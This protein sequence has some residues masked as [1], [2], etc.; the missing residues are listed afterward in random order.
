MPEIDALPPPRALRASQPAA[1]PL[2]GALIESRQR[3][4]DLV[5]MAADLAFETDAW[6]RFSFLAPDAVLGW[7]ASTLLGQPA[8]LLLADPANGY[9]PF[10][11]VAPIQR[12]RAWLKR[13]DGAVSCLAF[14]AAPLLD[15]QGRVVGARGAAM[16]VTE[17]DRREAQVSAALRRGEVIEHILWRMRQEVMAPKMMAAVL[18]ALLNALGAEGAAVIDVL[19]AGSGP[20]L[21]HQGGGGASAVLGTALSLLQANAETPAQENA[22]NGR[23]VLVCPCQTR[24]GEHIGLGIWRTP[25]SRAWDTDDQILA[26]SAAT[27]VRMVLEHEAI[28]REMAKQARTDPLTG[29]LNRRAFLEEMARHID[30]LEREGLPG[31]LMFAD[32]D[33][34]KPLNDR[35][36]H[37][38]GDEAL[39]QVA[40]LLRETVRPTDLVARLGGDE[41]AVWL[42][43][44]DHLTTAERAEMLR[45]QTPRTLDKVTGGQGPALGMSIGIATRTAGRG[46][47][48]DSLIRRADQA[49]YEVKRNGRGHWRVSH[50]SGE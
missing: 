32:L 33:N 35:L 28:Q 34:F 6:G 7:S 11:L 46:E 8:E 31:T 3:W 17:Q 36:G 45:V 24:F 27:I 38:A 42:N 1:D 39:R 30:R 2:R 14:A 15:A 13:P 37:D 48:I 18:D 4:R 41:F 16:D 21:L 25:G 29:L 50:E 12:R 10:R 40:K 5:T 43:G 9:N 19:G 49:M 44:A 47:D 22:A 23:P 20:K 26:A